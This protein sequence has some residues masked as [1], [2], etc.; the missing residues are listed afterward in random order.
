MNDGYPGKISYDPRTHFCFDKRILHYLRGHFRSIFLAENSL[1][2]I[3]KLLPYF[4]LYHIARLAKIC[5]CWLHH[6][7]V[8]FKQNYDQNF[9]DKSS[10]YP[11]CRRQPKDLTRK[12]K[13]RIFFQKKVGSSREIKLRKLPKE[14]LGNTGLTVGIIGTWLSGFKKPFWC[15]TLGFNYEALYN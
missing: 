8:I 9:A 11:R 10:I 12:F 3:W 2:C 13:L 7:A 6:A 15:L 4:C 14:L 5:V 1:Q